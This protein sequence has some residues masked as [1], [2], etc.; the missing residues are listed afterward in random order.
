MGG[1]L[2]EGGNEIFFSGRNNLQVNLGLASSLVLH[3]VKFLHAL[4]CVFEHNKAVG[5][6]HR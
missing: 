4:V 5:K 1:C 3:L 2:L 6:C